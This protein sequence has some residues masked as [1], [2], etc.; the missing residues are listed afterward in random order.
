MAENFFTTLRDKFQ[1]T[2]L[3]KSIYEATEGGDNYYN[4]NK[5]PNAVLSDEDQS[6]VDELPKEVQLDIDRYLSIFKNDPTLVY[7]YIAEIKE[8]GT[9][10]LLENRD[11]VEANASDKFDKMRYDDYKYLNKGTYDLQFDKGSE[12]A[13]EFKKAILDTTAV[14]IVGGAGHGLYQTARGTSALLASLSDLYLDTDYLK[15]VEEVL[16]QINLA[17]VLQ[18]PEPAFAQFV[19]L[20]TQ[21]GTPVGIAQKIAK[22]IIGKATKTAL[23]KK[24]LMSAAATS[25]VGKVAT[26]AAKFAGYWALPVGISDAVVSATG[27]ETLGGIFGKTEEEGGNWLQQKML[28]TEPESLEGLEGKEKAAAILRN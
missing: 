20:L 27:Q 8:K 18:R 19:S 21:Y 15:V 28:A 13:K 1:T 24:A 22:K 10:N 2:D 25:S 14:D 26:N 11:F 5:R 23:A 12:G 7:Q 9:S 6:F 17:E 4:D 3:Y 16:P